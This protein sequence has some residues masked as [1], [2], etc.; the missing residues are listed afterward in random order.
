MKLRQTNF[1][2]RHK[3]DEKIQIDVRMEAI[4]TRMFEYCFEEREFKQ[5]IG[6]ALET[7]REDMVTEAITRG[8]DAELLNY[9]FSLAYSVI[10][11]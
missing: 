6:I 2:N 7:R 1:E 9:A 4:V 11:N 10:G 8:G 5:A 3:A